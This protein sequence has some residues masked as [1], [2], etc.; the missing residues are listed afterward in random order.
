MQSVTVP[1]S[2]SYGTSNKQQQYQNQPSSGNN[3]NLSMAAIVFSFFPYLLIAVLMYITLKVLG[4]YKE[5]DRGSAIG[6][7][8][9]D[10]LEALHR[11][12]TALR[13]NQLEKE[14]AQLCDD[15]VLY[16]T[17]DEEHHQ[18]TGAERP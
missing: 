1:P 5:M 3:G 16:T 12:G 10:V 17:I 2:S 15:G 13:M 6:I 18:T 9:T 4:V 8:M 14:V 11:R 7:A